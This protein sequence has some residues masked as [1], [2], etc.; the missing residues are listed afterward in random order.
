MNFPPKHLLI[1]VQE[2]CHD[3]MMKTDASLFSKMEPPGGHVL[4]GQNMVH[5]STSTVDTDSRK[6]RTFS[7]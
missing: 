2:A 7:F 1:L 4:L 5:V 3:V 6:V